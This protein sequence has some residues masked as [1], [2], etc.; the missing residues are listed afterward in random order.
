ME[1]DSG[2]QRQKDTSLKRRERRTG[3]ECSEG[4]QVTKKER[5]RRRTRNETSE[6]SVGNDDNIGGRFK[7]EDWWK[8]CVVFKVNDWRIDVFVSSGGGVARRK[9]ERRETMMR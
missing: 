3:N 6:G 4:R 8:A 2:K 5:K 9:K 7:D 1:D